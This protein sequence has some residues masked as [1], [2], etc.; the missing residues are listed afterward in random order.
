MVDLNTI[1]EVASAAGLSDAILAKATLA[2][3]VANAV[4]RAIP[5]NKKGVLGAV[6][7][8]AKVLGLYIPNRVTST[9]STTSVTEAL[10]DGNLY[11]RGAH[12]R[13]ESM[14]E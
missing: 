9:H 3:L 12:G 8:L 5:D 2:I 13:F 1:S 14:A 10:A 6:R 7:K 4:G 11:R